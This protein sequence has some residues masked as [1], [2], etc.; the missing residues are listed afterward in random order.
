MISLDDLFLEEINLTEQLLFLNIKQINDLFRFFLILFHLILHFLVQHL[1]MD[2]IFISQGKT[3][4]QLRTFLLLGLF[5][6]RYIEFFEHGIGK[7]NVD[8]IAALIIGNF[9]F[10]CRNKVIL[11]GGFMGNFRSLANGV[12]IGIRERLL[13]CS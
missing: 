8:E 2:K 13:L 6:Q 11:L 4:K 10:N 3:L 7:N 9:L 5:F 12:V 1:C